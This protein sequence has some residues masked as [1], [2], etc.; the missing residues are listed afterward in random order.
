VAR[1]LRI[2]VITLLAIALLLLVTL[3]LPVKGWR[4]GEPA[5]PRLEATAAPPQ[6][7]RPLR[8]WVD[9]DAACGHGPRTDPDDCLALLLLAQSPEIELVGIST[10]FGNAALEVTD[11]T[12]RALADRLP[13]SAGGHP[14]VVRGAAGPI[15]ASG[16][17]ARGTGVA[18]ALGRA[19]EDG[20]LVVLALGPLTNL[21]MVFRDRPDLRTKVVRIVAVMGRRRG[22]LFHP[23]EGQSA[24]SLLGHGPVFRDFNFA[25]DPE[26]ALALVGMGLPLTLLP[27]EAAREIALTGGN[28]DRMA[29]A[30]GASRWVADRAR[31]WLN[32][33]E[34]DIGRDGFY[35]F[36][37]VAAGYVA[38]PD[39][40]GCATVLAWVGKDAGVFGW[41]GQRGLFVK[42]RAELPALREAAAPAEYCPD[43]A[44]HAGHWL[45]TRLTESRQSISGRR[46]P[47]PSTSAAPPRR[48]PGC[49]AD[50]S[51]GPS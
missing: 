36:D 20:P 30:G 33:W 29:A 7:P 2:L 26:A 51:S 38:R 21:A 5:G 45:V 49:R 18:S 25:K 19:L 46:L 39:L 35:P 3:A 17:A 41:L 11:S 40:A 14:V 31:G 43:L 8:L 44:Q 50:P 4:R 9:T 47:P 42:S 12:T 24:P 48:S 16:V 32:Y 37:L 15:K 1:F 13:A 34:H 10:V 23:V 27:Y 6:W 28:L 22:H